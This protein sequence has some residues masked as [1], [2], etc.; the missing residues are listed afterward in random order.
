MVF[1]AIIDQVQW[2][3]DGSGLIF[4]T[5]QFASGFGA[6]SAQEDLWTVTLAGEVTQRLPFFQGGGLFLALPNG[7]IILSKR[8]AIEQV[9]ADGS[10]RIRLVTFDFINTASE[11]VYY[12]IL[13]LARNGNT[14]YTAVP[15]A[16]PFDPKAFTQLWRIAGGE[17]E[18]IGSLPH[19]ILFNPVQWSATGSRLG[20]AAYASNVTPDIIVADGNGD[21][22]AVYATVEQARFFGW[23]GDGQYFLFST[24]GNLAVGQVGSESVEVA[25]PAGGVVQTAVWLTN[26]RYLITTHFAGGWRIDSAHVKG[27][28]SELLIISG[29]GDMAYDIWLP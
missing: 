11:Y 27:A 24:P 28:M 14:V 18:E 15:S 21:N 13:Q 12:P 9:N 23:S 8:D 20:Y 19:T 6:T 16:D 3:P 7:Q 4:N 26:G 29:E 1:S 2:L 22:A 10:N 25:I 17:A 5:A